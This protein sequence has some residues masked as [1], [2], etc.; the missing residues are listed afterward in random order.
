MRG[1][2]K[3]HFFRVGPAIVVEM[4]LQLRITL[5][6]KLGSHVGDFEMLTSRPTSL[7]K[8]C[9]TAGNRFF[10]DS[11]SSTKTATSLAST[12]NPLASTSAILLRRAV[13]SPVVRGLPF[14]F[15]LRLGKKPLPVIHRVALAALVV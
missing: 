9:S 15:P 5:V 14:K 7:S 4:K 12:I 1:P 11:A 3:Q 10:P 8:I 13:S 2:E 6:P